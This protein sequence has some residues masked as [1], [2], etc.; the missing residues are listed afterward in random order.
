MQAGVLPTSLSGGGNSSDHQR[1][2]SP[3]IHATWPACEFLEAL[4]ANTKRICYVYRDLK[5]AGSGQYHPM[6][7]RALSLATARLS[8]AGFLVATAAFAATVF[9]ARQASALTTIDNIGTAPFPSGSTSPQIDNQLSLNSNGIWAVKTFTTGSQTLT[10]KSIE[11]ALIRS[12]ATATNGSISV[13]VYGT[14]TA[15]I[16]GSTILVPTGNRL[17]ALDYNCPTCFTFD[18]NNK[19]SDGYTTLTPGLPSIQGALTGD[20][21]GFNFQPNSSY[22]LVFSRITGGDSIAWRSKNNPAPFYTASG[23]IT[24]NNSTGTN[25][26]TS[27]G[28]STTP[29][30]I[31]GS[32]QPETSA[33]FRSNW[34]T[35]GFD[36]VP[37]PAFAGLAS[38]F[39]MR[40]YSRRLRRRIKSAAISA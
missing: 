33:T 7:F 8:T 5:V 4:A 18:G 35:L 20:L 23:P 6:S 29:I 17:A 3:E 15:T 31:T 22:A 12:S 2:S 21:F 24:F 28:T 25:T 34:L 36:P 9:E 10:L 27:L 1:D 40:D 30:S 26:G 16:S 38:F 11:A 37:A 19:F 32:W 39:G 13:G 14:A